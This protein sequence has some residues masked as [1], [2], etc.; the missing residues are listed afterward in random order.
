MKHLK[1]SI[2]VMA[3]LASQPIPPLAADT[4]RPETVTQIKNISEGPHLYVHGGGKIHVVDADDFKYQGS[5][6]VGANAGGQKDVFSPDGKSLY[7]AKIYFPQGVNGKRIDVVEKWDIPTL[8]LT[9]E[10]ALPI[11]KLAIRGADYALASLSSDGR[12]MYVQNATPATSISTFDVNRSSFGSEIPLPGCWGVYPV[13]G[14]NRFVA[15]CGDGRLSTVSVSE[16]GSASGT[17]RSEKIFDVDTDPLFTSYQRIDNNLLMISFNGNFYRI[18]ISGK[19]ARL[20]QKVALVE[21]VEGG[22]K[23]SGSQPIALVSGSSVVYILMRK[24]AK[25]GDHAEPANEVWA[26]DLAKRK[27]ISRSSTENAV[28]ITYHNGDNPYL[29]VGVRNLG[30]VRYVVD[31]AAAY[32]VRRDK[33]IRLDGFDTIAVR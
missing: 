25:E 31:P 13:W 20:T 32:T 4:I 17:E 30:V 8:T 18:D 24:V 9:E 14:S 12:W 28:S 1:A 22:W 11:T 7:L 27:V 15:L 21:G 19:I 2:L 29:F 6:S 10:T 3:T 26:Y 5:I 16:D 33:M 23:P